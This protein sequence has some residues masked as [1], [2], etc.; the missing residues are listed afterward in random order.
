MPHSRFLIVGQGLVGTVVAHEL[1]QHGIKALVIDNNHRMSASKVAA[2]LFNPFIFKYVTR[3]WMVDELLPAMHHT[4]GL[5]EQKLN[6]KLVHNTGMVRV[7]GSESEQKHW[8]KKRLRPEYAAF[9]GEDCNDLIA[10]GIDR[11]F[12]NITIPS[13]GWLDLPTLL[14]EYRK[15]LISEN[16]LL[17]EPFVHEDL[18]PESPVK[19]R[20]MEF[21]TVIFCEGAAVNQNPF[22]NHLR[23]RHTKGEVLEIKDRIPVDLPI[24]YG[25]F[26]VPIGNSK[27]RIGATFEWDELNDIPTDSAGQKM[28]ETYTGFFKS[29]PQMVRHQ[30][31]VRPTAD[32]RK[33]FAGRHSQYPALAILN[34]TGSKGVMIAPWAATQLIALLINNQKLH[35]EIDLHRTISNHTH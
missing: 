20:G 8:A 15:Y 11:G 10:A 25:Q 13:A 34:A 22:F 19:Y 26:L 29:T 7:I 33:P 18:N 2:G 32:D 30:A 1:E 17:N 9:V 5:I 24:Q 21:D 28:L 16:R 3:S 6:L 31:G 4:Y 12:G 23:F 35:P 27:Y 14:L